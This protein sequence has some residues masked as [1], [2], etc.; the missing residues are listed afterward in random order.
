VKWDQPNLAVAGTA[1]LVSLGAQVIPAAISSR[2]PS[3]FSGILTNPMMIG[4]VLL[5]VLHAVVNY[6]LR[7][8]TERRKEKDEVAEPVAAN[9]TEQKVDVA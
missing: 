5:M 9:S 7:P 8:I 3:M 2:L 6:G 1:I 4:I